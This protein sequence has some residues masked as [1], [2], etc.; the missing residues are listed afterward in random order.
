MSPS[1]E[2]PNKPVHDAQVDAGYKQPL[3]FEL[4]ALSAR[5]TA[6]EQK[7]VNL[8]SDIVG[9][10]QTTTAVPASTDIPNTIY[11]QIRIY[12]SG[13]TYRLYWYDAQNSEWRYATG[14]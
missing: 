10:F 14:T 4:D 11:D 12:K 2:V 1:N 6:L 9:L 13:T 7:P 3:S 8:N 5:I